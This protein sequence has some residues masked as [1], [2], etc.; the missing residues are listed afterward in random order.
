MSWILRALCLVG[1][2]MTSAHLSAA[3]ID[4]KYPIPFP[5]EDW[6]GWRGPF[7]TGVAVADQSPPTS[8]S[9]TENVL[10]KVP[11][12]GRGHGSP[13]VIGNRVYLA[14]AEVEPQVQSVMA[15]DRTTGKPFWK[16]KVH[17]GHFDTKGNAKS[18]HASSSV[19][20]DGERL[21]IAFSNHDAIW[22]TALSFDGEILWQTK[23]ADFVNHQGFGASPIVYGPL[24]LMA[25]D[26]KGGAGR[27]AGLDR[28]TGKVVWS[29][30]RP[31]LPNYCS[32]TV[33]HVAGRD[34]IIM[35]GCNLVQGLEPLTGKVLWETAGA[36]EECVTSTVTDG[37]HIYTTGGYP[38]NHV[39][40][41][42]ADGSG[43]VAWESAS[44][45]Y[46]P[47]MVIKDGYLYAILDAGVAICWKAD[48]G[49]EK[50]KQRLGGTFSASL[51]L[52]GD[53]IFGT[54]EA[55]KTTIWKANPK[56]FELVAE[57]QLGTE[58]FATPTICGSRIYA[59]VA[60][61]VDGQRQE[62]L[63]CLGETK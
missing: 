41:M 35:I 25:A 56:E 38:K 49:E 37:Q 44:R 52:V 10:W 24:V 30:P 45:V 20:S 36:T 23:V 46:V 28:Q 34:Q 27:V 14:T 6:P 51:V 26:S 1:L 43:K 16:K 29:N 5:K 4:V 50:W 13:T 42:L 17:T 2:S 47:S 18:S 31:K 53:Q 32:A 59:R 54:D 55:G 12:P 63:Y 11:V 22:T 9:D 48:T 3:E 8:W 58:A 15:F 61:Q 60:D 62:W 21:F 19:S 57:N 33:L 40:A 39:A 7:G